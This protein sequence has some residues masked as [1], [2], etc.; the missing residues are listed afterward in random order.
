MFYPSRGPATY[1][2]HIAEANRLRREVLGLQLVLSVAGNTPVGEPNPIDWDE[3]A[4]EI[5]VKR[6]RLAEII[7]TSTT[8]D[9]Y[10]DAGKVF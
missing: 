1:L 2:T 9:A 4:Q 7:P 10:I 3:T 6:Q 5:E 8:V